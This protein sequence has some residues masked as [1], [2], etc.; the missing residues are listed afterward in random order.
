VALSVPV[1]LDQLANT[2]STIT[3]EEVETSIPGKKPRKVLLAGGGLPKKGAIDWTSDLRVIT[4]WFPG[5]GIDATQ[6]VLGPTD[7]PSS[8]A[9]E[10]NRTRL[11]RTPCFYTDENGASR[12][13]IDP[14][15]LWNIIEDIQRAGARLRVT[16]SVRGRE[17]VGLRRSGVDRPVEVSVVR[18]GRLKV[19]KL[20][21]VMHTDIPWTM[22]WH[23]ASRG[24]RQARVA[25]VQKDEDLSA[26]TSAL[27]TAIIALDD[28]NPELT[29]AEGL[30]PTPKKLTL[31]QLESVANLPLSLV[32]S[33][34]S[35]LRYNL[36]QFQRAGLIAK[37]IQATPFAI[38]NSVIDF[39]RDSVTT[40]ARFV[41]TMSRVPYEKTAKKT[42][43]ADLNRSWN[44]FSAVLDRVEGAA[45]SASELEQKMRRTIVAGANR[46]SL[47][48]RDSAST[49]AGDIIAIHIAKAGDTPERVSQKYYNT[50]DQSESLLRANRLPLHT[51]FFRSGLILIIPV[52]ATSTQ[53]T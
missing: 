9:G 4:S 6:Q 32:K 1:P 18:E 38:E 30:K 37:K 34:Q 53:A 15:A 44:Y 40:S 41:D 21:P 12:T 31:G 11:G 39:A 50:P 8:W 29:E 35:K 23:W 20:T 19:M 48:I 27:S 46:G 2:G 42:K 13:V 25:Q 28:T 36:G 52:L 16:W 51:P 5:N 22:E 3:I 43:I 45:R 14:I 10:W 7:P 17:L 26:A 24:P 33:M 49:R 47:S